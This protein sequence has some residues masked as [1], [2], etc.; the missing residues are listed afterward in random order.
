MNF[1]SCAYLQ[2][3]LEILIKVTNVS[4]MLLQTCL[5]FY[6]VLLN[7]V[8]HSCTWLQYHVQ[9]AHLRQQCHNKCHNNSVTTSAT[10]TVSQQVPQQQCHNKC[11]NNS[12]TTT[13]PQQQCHNNCHNNSVT[14]SVTT[15]A[16]TTVSQQQCHNSK[17]V[18]FQEKLLKVLKCYNFLW[19]QWQHSCSLAASFANCVMTL[20]YLLTYL[21]TYL[22]HGAQSFL[23]S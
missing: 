17:C 23:R 13:V 12:A 15:S 2:G 22:P 6:F 16:T 9:I 8:H 10:T 14:T 5:R 19:V 11:H 4:V 21:L 1:C 3:Q 20:I 18:T 7:T